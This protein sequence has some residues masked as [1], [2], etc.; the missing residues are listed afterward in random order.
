MKKLLTFIL[1]FVL[2]LILLCALLIAIAYTIYH[3]RALS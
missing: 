2:G 1:W 3:F